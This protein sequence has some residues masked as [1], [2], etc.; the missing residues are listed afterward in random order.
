MDNCLMMH[1][2]TTYTVV[3]VFTVRVVALCFVTTD[4]VCNSTQQYKTN[5]LLLHTISMNEPTDMYVGCLMQL[6]MRDVY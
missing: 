3:G 6:K 4:V 5:N 1:Q 2:D